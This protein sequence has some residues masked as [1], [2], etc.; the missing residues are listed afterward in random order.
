M[1]L[2]AVVRGII[3]AV[4]PDIA[5]VW[6]RNENYTTAADGT[7]VPQYVDTSVTVQV[8]DLTE[9]D[10]R[11]LQHTSNLNLQQV[12]RAAYMF[13]NPQGVVRVDVKGGDLLLF[14]QVV[15][16]LVYTWLI[17]AVIETWTPDMQGWGKV[18]LSLQ[19]DS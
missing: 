8:Q 19:V 11:K 14:P 2:H 1:N 6:R 9:K 3:P 18:A 16:G 17:A 10:M 12:S 15:G 5:A 4:N 7:Q 13:G